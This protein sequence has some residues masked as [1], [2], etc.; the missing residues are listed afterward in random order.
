M[1]T[2]LRRNTNRHSK[3]GKRRKKKQIWRN[4]TG[5][6][7]KMRLKKKSYPATV[8]VGYMKDKK[9]KGKI[10]KKNPIIVRTLK[11]LGRL[12]NSQIGIIANIGKKKKLEIVERAKEKGI[13]LHN[14]N[15]KQYLKKNK[16]K[17]KIKEVEKK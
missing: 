8:S 4:P 10:K 13:H 16:T 5:R 15:P 12:A 1:P 17:E 9:E 11:D 14:I 3:L 2:F 7:N 6:H